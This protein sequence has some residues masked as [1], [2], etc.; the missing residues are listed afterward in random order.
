[1][2][3][4]RAAEFLALHAGTGFVLPN[5][6]DA[7]SARLLAQIGFPAIA[8]TS[9]GIAW[10]YG[11]QDGGVI[12]FD[13]MLERVREITRVARVPVSADLESGYADPGRAVSQAVSAGAVGGN[14]EDAADG[15]LFD[16]GLATDNIAAARNAA[17][18]GTFVLNARTDAYFSKFDGDPFAETVAR[19]QRYV[20]A[21]ADCIFV[22]GVNDADTI[23]RLAAE[24][25]APLNVVAGLSAN[26][27]DAPTLFEL[28]V[29]R[30][31]VGGS[32][33]RAAMSAIEN[34]GRE[35]LETGTLGFLDGALGYADLQH[36]FAL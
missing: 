29:K 1:M 8:T 3:A 12:G 35:L 36:R 34:A 10:S 32:L 5:A 23:R 2:R 31:S 24:I 19:A 26:R 28:G 14:L 22:P 4:D 13:T 27:I 33:A 30:V 9:A 7:G 17:A 25:P 18:K 21:G 20:D 11:V 15:Y 6:W 16:I